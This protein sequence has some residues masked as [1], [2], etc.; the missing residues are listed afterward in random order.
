MPV[1]SNPIYDFQKAYTA[2]DL[3]LS[4]GSE[5]D[6]WDIALIGKNLTDELISGNSDDQPRC[7]EMGSP[8]RIASA[9][10]R[11]RQPIRFRGV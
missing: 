9:L 4:L 11:F 1:L 7:Q 10:A 5:D 3:G 2:Y 8:K 6:L